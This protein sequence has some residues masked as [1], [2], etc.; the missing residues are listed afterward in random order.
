MS[1]GRQQSTG[2]AQRGDKISAADIRDAICR[3]ENSYLPT[4]H[5]WR[6]FPG[7]ARSQE[8]FTSSSAWSTP[9]QLVE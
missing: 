1:K 8:V 6:T 7:T 5:F 4:E 9:A 3:N 2:A